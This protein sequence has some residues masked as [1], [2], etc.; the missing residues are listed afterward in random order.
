MSSF[1]EANYI[2]SF[3]PEYKNNP[4]ILALPPINT[5]QE[6]ITQLLNYPEFHDDERIVSK[7]DRLHM[8]YRLFQVFQ[9]LSFHLDLESRISRLIRQSYITRNPVSAEYKN[10]LENRNLSNKVDMFN[11][12]GLMCTVIGISGI[13]KTT[14]VN[15]V[16]KM[17]P[18]AIKHDKFNGFV[19][20]MFQVV[21]IK[22]EAPHNGSIKGL[23]ISFFQAV[24]Q[25]LNTT[26]YK[27]YG[28]GRVTV[29]TMLTA[30]GTIV[31]QI[32]LA[33][34]IIDEIQFLT[35]SKSGA[36]EVLN[37]LVTTTN[38]LGISLLLVSTPM[39]VQI[40]QKEFKMARRAESAGDLIID[41]LEKGPNWDLLIKAIWK[42][43]W[44][45]NKT[46]LTPELSNTLYEESQGITD[47][48]VKLYELT[49]I[50]SITTNSEII[51]PTLIKKVA[52]DKLKLLKPMLSALKKKNLKNI[53][54]YE[55]ISLHTLDVESIIN[56]HK[57]DIEVQER[58]KL[59]RKT[60]NEVNKKTIDIKRNEVLVKLRAIN[61]ESKK[62]K[63]I[64]EKVIND[65]RLSAND[66]VFK[67]LDNIANPEIIDEDVN[68]NDIR[69]IV[70]E[71]AED[72]IDAYNALVNGG[73]IVKVVG[74]VSI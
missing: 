5:T 4:L 50:H 34:L 2:D 71:S 8:I 23:C 69:V 65:D 14:A 63:K 60:Q 74:G 30:M 26:Y 68:I 58:L 18:Q 27:R 48:A 51:T 46:E 38:E 24:D 61:K 9:P 54:K 25:L 59:I 70:K 3:I 66:I 19:L 16:L 36:S 11:S 29:N 53:A 56:Q 20:S 64:M 52:R 62:A 17:Y 32:N 1:I 41:R 57:E 35:R 7:Q 31:K 12:T 6:A 67:I 28:T 15:R 21:Y 40:L 10:H 72:G 39:G 47:I 22:I 73:V 37:F 44:T 13:G 49:Q 55:D 45:I 42:Y 33:L 43:Q